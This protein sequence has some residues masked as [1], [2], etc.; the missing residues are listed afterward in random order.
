MPDKECVSTRAMAAIGCGTSSLELKEG[1]G[2]NLVIYG[3]PQDH[4]SHNYRRRRT[5]QEIIYDAGPDR[6][7]IKDGQRPA[8]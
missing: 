4:E 2:T 1:N 3:Q 8:G 5:L 6:I 7:L